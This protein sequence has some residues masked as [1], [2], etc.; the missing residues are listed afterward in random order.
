MVQRTSALLQ[1]LTESATLAMAR[2]AAE[3]K[4]A[5]VDVISLSLGEPDFDTPELIKAAGIRGI[6]ENY[7]HYTPVPGLLSLREAIAR[8]LKRDNGL[9]Y[10]PSQIV[11]SNGAKQSITNAVLALVDPG[12]EVLI[13]APYWVSY[14][15]MVQLAGGT[16]VIL[17]TSVEQDFKPTPEALEAAITPR[18]R[19]LIY[20]S[21]CNPSGSVFSA[22]EI[23]GIAG[24][25]E[26]NP[27]VLAIS[28]EI[29]ELIQFEGRSPS[30]AAHASISDRV[31]TVN[32]VS[33]GFAMTGWRL[34]YIA[35]PQWIADACSKIQG[36]VTSA[37]CSIAQVAAE[38]AVSADPSI[39]D[40][41]RVAFLRRRN[42]VLEKVAEIP[43]WK[44]HRPNGAFYL[45]P[46]VSG[47]LGK[48]YQGQVLKD[49]D[50]VA[51]FL[52]SAAQVAVVGGPAF[53][54]PECI[55]I[56]YAAADDVLLEAMNRIIAA[57]KLLE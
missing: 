2:K 5:G 13:P 19:L 1:R 56:S 47:W 42:L 24:V 29:Y 41:M 21:P 9:D 20:S 50:D 6:E 33:K 52:L 51:L 10:K 18:T 32:G 53:G 28:D 25:L 17:P 30:L 37:P 49:G 15:D 4:A 38:A 31:M 26:R 55:R 46:D 22:E 12:D 3:L 7:S 8:K 40:G 39:A 57:A 36:Q 54:T 11:V 34:G 48:S 35:A 45:F 27:H 43:G 23:A 16:P 14:V 44:S